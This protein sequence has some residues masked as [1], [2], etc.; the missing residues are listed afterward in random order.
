MPGQGVAEG[1]DVMPRHDCVKKV[2]ALLAQ[3]GDCLQRFI[4]IGTKREERIAIATERKRA[5]KWRR[6]AT[7]LMA[8]FCP[9]CGVD[10]R[11]TLT[12]PGV[13]P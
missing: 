13:Q 5:T 9:F 10:L 2:N 8:S 6:G 4:M 12:R 1:V 7:W 11:S 3:Q